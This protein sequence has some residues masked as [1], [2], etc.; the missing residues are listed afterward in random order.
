MHGVAVTASGYTCAS[1]ISFFQ[2]RDDFSEWSSGADSCLEVNYKTGLG[3]TTNNSMEVNVWEN[4]VEAAR[5]DG[6]ELQSTS[7]TS[8]NIGSVLI[9]SGWA[10]GDEMRIQIK[11]KVNSTS[12]AAVYIGKIH[13]R[14]KGI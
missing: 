2:A 1:A 12:S 9:G 3:A 6:G 13:L 14:Y 8:T 11:V 7:W 4:G 10:A 5:Y